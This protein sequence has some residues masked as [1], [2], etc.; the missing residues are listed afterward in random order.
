[1]EFSTSIRYGDR[2][3]PADETQE[4]AGR[5][6]NRVLSLTT[7][8]TCLQHSQRNCSG[9]GP[10]I[11]S[12]DHQAETH[13]HPGSL[14]QG[15]D[16]GKSQAPC[17]EKT[18]TRTVFFFHHSTSSSQGQDQHSLVQKGGCSDWSQY[19]ITLQVK[20]GLEPPSIHPNT[21]SWIQT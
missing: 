20:G 10:P 18:G 21:K 15:K 5:E 19:N 2:D 3:A 17:S 9:L 4:E 14:G 8:L 11:S 12:H 16:T 1:M 7:S 6:H 13:F